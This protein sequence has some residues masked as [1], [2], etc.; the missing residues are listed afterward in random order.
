MG[1]TKTYELTGQVSLPRQRF[2]KHPPGPQARSVATSAWYRG[3]E[4]TCLDSLISYA[5]PAD[6]VD[7]SLGQ[8]TPPRGPLTWTAA[9]RRTVNDELLMPLRSRTLNDAARPFG[10]A[11]AV[12]GG[13]SEA[14]LQNWYNPS[15]GSQQ[16]RTPTVR[17]CSRTEVSLPSDRSAG[18]RPYFR[19]ARRRC[20]NRMI[21][22]VVRA[23]G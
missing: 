5:R 12:S 7:P 11:C 3:V 9:S 23:S 2:Q 6:C 10:S 1:G 8:C 14:L 17:F 4:E 16:E 15:N 21:N 18:S 22:W 19:P 13:I 20:G